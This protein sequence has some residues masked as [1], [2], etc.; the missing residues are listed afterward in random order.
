M[1]RI[2]Y[3][4]Y[5]DINTDQLDPQPPH[6]GETE[7]KNLKAK[8]EFANYQ[9]WLED[10]QRSYAKS[11]GVEYTL[12]KADDQWIEYR[13]DLSDRYP[14]LTMYNIVNFYKIY[15]MYQLK[16]FYDEILYM[17][18]DVVPVTSESFF[19]IWDLS[20]GMVIRRKMPMVD[21]RLDDMKVKE[22]YFLEFGK[23]DSIRSPVAKYWNNKALLMEYDIDR[24]DVPVYNTGI[25]GISRSELEKLDYFK[26]FSDLIQDMTT[27]KEEIPS[28]WP[29]YIQAMFGWDNETLWGFL[30]V[31]NNMKVQSIDDYWHYFLDRG[32]FIPKAAKLVHVIHKDFKVVRDWCEKNNI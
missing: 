28:M 20:K 4:I 27:I 14:E 17:D 13:D 10:R 32:N 7:D 8:R 22:K 18:L 5:I 15:L 12:F 3:S 2:I 21:I 23:T 9:P 16:E 1:K 19:N 29:T 31:K 11:I 30:C 25:V 6:H 24:D 26:N